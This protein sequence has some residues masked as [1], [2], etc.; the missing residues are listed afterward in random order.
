MQP[1][2]DQ[3]I[4]LLVNAVR[5]SL[6]AARGEPDRPGLVR[7]VRVDRAGIKGPTRGQARSRRFRRTSQGFYV[8]AE[9]DAANPEQRI[10]EASV[11][12][13]AFGGV[14]GW[15]A[16]RWLGGVWFDGSAAAGTEIR[17]VTLATGYDDVLSQPGINISQERL[18]PADLDIC[19]GLRLTRA[20]RSLLFEMRYASSDR[21]AVVA[22]DMAAYSDLASLDEITAYATR[23]NGWT[24]IPR[25]RASLALADENSWSPQETRMRLRWMLDADL[26]RPLCNAPIFDLDGQH[27]GTPDLFDPE[28]GVVGEY[29]GALHLQGHQRRRDRQR[30]EAFRAH[31]LEYFTVLSGDS[32]EATADRMLAARS[33]A[34]FLCEASR[35][36]T[37]K[38]PRWWI[39][40]S[41]VRQRRALDAAEREIWLRTRLKVG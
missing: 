36:W 41:T 10:L 18:G 26:P 24:G 3:G 33:R 13:P 32:G 16:L 9:V 23:H 31:G 35:D 27:V 19:N 20:L 7:P 8:P 25:A 21:E 15:A 6:G 1:P 37:L 39:P 14:S 40:T 28:A 30:E 22:A 5:Q 38:P 2:A 29:D 4:V 34:R 17:P 12:L 11:V